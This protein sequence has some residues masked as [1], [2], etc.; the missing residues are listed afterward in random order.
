[1]SFAELE[2][3]LRSELLAFHV[4]YYSANVMRLAVLGRQTFEAL[5]DLVLSAFSPIV[6]KNLTPPFEWRTRPLP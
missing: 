6:N 3:D 5:Q 4:R 1:M 2:V